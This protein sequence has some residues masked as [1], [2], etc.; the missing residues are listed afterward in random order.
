MK[1]RQL[2]IIEVFPYLIPF[3]SCPNAKSAK[4][5]CL[6]FFVWYFYQ[7]TMGKVKPKWKNA[8]WWQSWNVKNVKYAKKWHLQFQLCHQVALLNF[9]STFPICATLL[10]KVKVKSKWK[11]ATWWQSWNVK[12]VKYAKKWHLQFQL[13]HQV[14]LLNFYSTFPIYATLLKKV[15][16][17]FLIRRVLT[18][19]TGILLHVYQVSLIAHQI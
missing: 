3:N 19:F 18:N 13:C 6:I 4:L 17:R 14:A 5:G 2:H 10:K 12:N 15:S 7:A 8:T 11:N 9:Y 16:F 1:H